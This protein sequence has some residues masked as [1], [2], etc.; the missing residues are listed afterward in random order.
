MRI[1]PSA[2]GG[3]GGNRGLLHVHLLLTAFEVPT[4][5]D[6]TIGDTVIIVTYVIDFKTEIIFP[7]PLNN[8]GLIQRGHRMGG[9]GCAELEDGCR[10][11]CQH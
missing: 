11:Q 6:P 5:G 1:H 8:T 7:F 9:D 4:E 3:A 2:A 10:Q